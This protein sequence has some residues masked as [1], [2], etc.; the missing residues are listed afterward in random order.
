MILTFLI[1]VK[2]DQKL[3]GSSLSV[4]RNDTPSL[5]ESGVRTKAKK[6]KKDVS[7]SFKQDDDEMESVDKKE[8]TNGYSSIGYSAINGGRKE[9]D[10]TN[11]DNQNDE[12]IRKDEA[13]TNENNSNTQL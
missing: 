5:K 4:I 2:R 3:D 13:E 11:P 6:P 7:V 9:N 8:T 10:E 1:L 12:E